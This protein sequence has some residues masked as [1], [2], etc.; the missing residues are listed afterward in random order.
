MIHRWRTIAPA[1]QRVRAPTPVNTSMSLQRRQFTPRVVVVTEGSQ[2]DF[3]NQDPFSHNVF[4]KADVGPFDAEVYGRGRTRSN[5][6]SRQ[7]SIPSTP[8]STRA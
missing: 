4:S 8:T 3:P 6:F 7:A 2:V 5:V 1:I